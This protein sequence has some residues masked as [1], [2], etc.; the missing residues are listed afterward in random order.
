MRLAILAI[1][2]FPAVLLAQQAVLIDNTA[3]VALNDPHTCCD[4]LNSG[5]CDGKV[6]VQHIHT[7]H[8]MVEDC[9]SFWQQ[10]TCADASIDTTGDGIGDQWLVETSP[11]ANDRP[12]TQAEADTVPPTSLSMT[13]CNAAKQNDNECRGVDFDGSTIIPLVQDCRKAYGT[14]TRS[15]IKPRRNDGREIWRRIDAGSP[16]DDNDLASV[17]PLPVIPPEK[18][19]VVTASAQ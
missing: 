14:W 3:C 4:G 19:A 6:L 18:R 8:T 2:F 17:R 13:T 7:R 16:P 15:F 9:Q 10:V 12:C 11:G 1:F 5:T